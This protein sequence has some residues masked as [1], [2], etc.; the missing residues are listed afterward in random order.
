MKKTYI[1]PKMQVVVLQSADG[2]LQ[3]TSNL[4]SMQLNDTF[5]VT[6]SNDEF[7]GEAAVKSH[8][9]YVNWDELE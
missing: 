2:L 4:S 9:N 3:N 8:H 1:N 5:S 7:D 6:F